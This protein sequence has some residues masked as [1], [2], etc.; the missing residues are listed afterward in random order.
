VL[1]GAAATAAGL[2]LFGLL[3]SSARGYIWLTVAVAVVAWLV[4]LL[5]ARYGDRGVAVG[6]AISAGIGIAISFVLV[7]ARWFTSG[8][9][10]W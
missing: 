9:P 10:L 1:V 5:L 7:V 4:A 3:G 6:V 8:W 2:L